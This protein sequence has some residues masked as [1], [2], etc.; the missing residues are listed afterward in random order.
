MIAAGFGQLVDE[1]KIDEDIKPIL[2]L[3]IERQ[4]IATE[5]D[6]NFKFRDEY[7][8]NLNILKK[9]LEEA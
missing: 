6:T 7:T 4:I 8:S 1:G 5:L 3:A 9:V 2:R